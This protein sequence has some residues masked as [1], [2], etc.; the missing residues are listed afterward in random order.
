MR[1]LPLV[2]LAL[3]LA[4]FANAQGLP[5]GPITLGEGRLTLG[6]EASASIATTDD[7][8]GWFNYTDYE[9]NVLHLI[10]LGLS[11]ALRAG[12]RVTLLGE[13]RSENWG[14]VRPYGLY[15]R[16]RPWM[17]RVFDI[18]AGRIPPT[19]GTFGRRS[20]AADNPLI[21]YPLAYQYLTSLRPDAVPATPDDLLAM[22]G[23]G[24]RSSFPVGASN[25]DRGLPLVSAFRW[26]TGVQVRVGA[27]PVEVSAAVTT[28]TLSNPRV[29]DDN[30]GKQFSARVNVRPAVGLIVGAS[31]A[32]GAYV[33]RAVVREL[34]PEL[35]HRDYSQQA[36][37]LDVEYSRGYWLLRAEGLVSEWKVPLARWSRPVEPLR[38]AALMVE[39]RYKIV[40]GL[41]AAA[42]YDRLEFN[43][44][45]GTRRVAPWEAPVRRI[46]VGGGYYLRRNLLAKIVYQRNDRETSRFGRL[47]AGAAQ[48]LAWF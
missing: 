12:D 32:H 30:G 16:I 35:R 19:F 43:R 22:R 14:A 29:E 27:E 6:G 36:F 11:A 17:G 33:N 34:P 26:D 28:G 31:A 13:V 10:R 38:A 48:L 2:A 37:G 23:R 3:L 45:E 42:R 8:H 7:E 39:G 41:Y 15:V 21:G 40:P 18:Q 5:S 9:H 25:P 47:N 4:R 20:Y 44:I 24:W 1:C 46:E